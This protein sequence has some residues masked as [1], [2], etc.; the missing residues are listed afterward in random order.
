VQATLDDLTNKVGMLG[1][2][3]TGL[4]A[5]QDQAAFGVAERAKLGLVYTTN[6]V[7]DVLLKELNTKF[8]ALQKT[9]EGT[10]QELQAEVTLRQQQTQ[11]H[12]ETVAALTAQVEGLQVELAQLQLGQTKNSGELGP[13]NLW[14]E[15]FK[16]FFRGWESNQIHDGNFLWEQ[17]RLLKDDVHPGW[18]QLVSYDEPHPSGARLILN[19]RPFLEQPVA[20]A[21]NSIRNYGSASEPSEPYHDTSE[22]SPLKPVVRVAANLA[23]AALSPKSGAGPSGVNPLTT[24]V[25]A[26]TNSPLR[27][28][29][30]GKRPLL[31][32]RRSRQLPR[33]L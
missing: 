24:P 12:T 25:R 23:T 19:K 4:L 13:L 29:A 2:Q 22:P 14:A 8:E 1:P 21:A 32:T 18:R 6:T 20:H 10:A 16:N 27:I 31:L 7:H 3:M 5:N 28:I 30:A 11:Q 26:G 33:P 9:S 15:Q 17:I